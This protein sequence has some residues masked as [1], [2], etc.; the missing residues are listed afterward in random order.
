MR[1]SKIEQL[2]LAL[3]DGFRQFDRPT[4]RLGSG[5]AIINAAGRPVAPSGHKKS[6]IS[7]PART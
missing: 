5:I 7:S 2:R 4:N 3:R 1:G 6:R